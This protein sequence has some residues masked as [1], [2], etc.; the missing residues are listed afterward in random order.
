MREHQIQLKN[1]GL[2]TVTSASSISRWRRRLHPDLMQGGREQEVL[3]GEDQMWMCVYLLAYP[4]ARLDEIAAFVANAGTSGHIYSR[5]QVSRR[6]TEMN[7]TKKRTST[8]AHQANRPIN[9]L[10]RDIFWN[11]I[12]P[13]GL[14]GAERRGLIDVDE[15]GIEIQRCNCKYGHSAKEVRIVKPGHYSK[16]TKLTVI[17]AVEP[18]DPTLPPV[19]LESTE[20]PRRW[21]KVMEKAGTTILDFNDFITEIRV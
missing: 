21:L 20:R 13:F 4:E 14:M 19:V 8:E 15:Y 6:L 9:L 17:L 3:V 16:D 1:H 11:S 5:S 12:P 2:P 18:G 7:L 10:K